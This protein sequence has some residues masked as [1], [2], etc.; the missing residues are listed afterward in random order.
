MNEEQLTKSIDSMIDDLFAE[1]EAKEGASVEKSIDIAKDASKTADEAVGKAPKAQKDEARG[2]GRPKQISDVPQEDM[3]GRRDSDYDGSISENEGKED[4]PEEAKKQAQS[5]DQT[6]EK[7]R[8]GG[9]PKAPEMKP[10]KKSESGEA[11]ELSDEEYKEFL[12]FKKSKAE[13]AEKAAQAEELKKAEEAKK[14]QEDLIKSAVKEAVSG[15]REENEELRKSLAESQELLKAMASTPRQ[16]KS[17]TNMQALEKS[18]SPEDQD[19]GPKAF[20]KSEMLDGM[21]ELVKAG[22]LSENVVYE[23]DMTKRIA[24]PQARKVVEEYMNKR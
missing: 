7:K 12:E 15:I 18:M 14:E 4:E 22:K 16:P 13:A 3:D 8:M 6:Q 5:M 19:N 20:S 10:F 9:K 2:A 23:Y 24:D 1:P 21:E 11:E 17:I